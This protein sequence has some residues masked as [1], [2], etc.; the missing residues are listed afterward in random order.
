MGFFENR[1]AIGRIPRLFQKQV[2]YSVDVFT[3]A[4]TWYKPA[5]LDYVLAMIQGGGRGANAGRRGAA[6]SNRAG[7]YGI[8]G[9]FILVKIPASQL[10]STQ[11]VIVGAAGVG[12]PAVTTDN[13]S[14]SLGGDGGYSS[15]ADY[16]SEGGNQPLGLA[17][18]GGTTLVTT[19]NAVVLVTIPIYVNLIKMANRIDITIGGATARTYHRA[20]GWGNTVFIPIIPAVSVGGQ[21]NS[22][23][24]VV[25]SG[26]KW[27]IYDIDNT[28]YDENTASTAQGAAGASPTHKFTFG[29]LLS[30]YYP[31]FNPLDANYLIGRNGIGGGQGDTAGTIAGG[32]G[33]N[34][35]GYGGAGG[36][37]GASTNGA[38][39]GAGG[40]GSP[41]I[42]IVVNVMKYKP[43]F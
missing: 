36:G 37:G 5:D 21:I 2:Y 1:N 42:V 23:N 31:W 8:N 6:G 10:S 14:S 38:N 28:I 20:F 30:W 34:A 16:I 17:G 9:G 25:G 41:G 35:T 15:F 39:S 19:S 33:G 22:S 24:A 43:R 13:T 27:G 18:G 12:A 32:A 29:D 26:G 11:S 3:G 7:G 40:N 4:G